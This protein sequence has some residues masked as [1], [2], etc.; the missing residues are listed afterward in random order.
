MFL[1][2]AIIHQLLHCLLFPINTWRKKCYIGFYRKY[3]TPYCYCKKELK[4]MR[5]ILAAMFPFMLLTWLPLII[6]IN[7]GASMLLY[8][9]AYSNAIISAFDLY[10]IYILLSKI[11]GWKK[12]ILKSAN[13]Y[14][15]VLKKEIN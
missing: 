10:D 8:A 12:V 5:L 14:F 2:V 11:P 15:I 3:L 7:T 6:I 13:R 1:V 4:K 9:I